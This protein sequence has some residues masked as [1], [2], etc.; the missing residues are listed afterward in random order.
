MGYLKDIAAFLP[1]L[2]TSMTFP[3]PLELD[4]DLVLSKEYCLSGLKA[5]GK[6]VIQID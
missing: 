3:L 2:R 1:K 4:F 5:G 6:L